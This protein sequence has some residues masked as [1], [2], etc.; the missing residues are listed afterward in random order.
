MLSASS[1][2]RCRLPFDLSNLNDTVMKTR[3]YFGVLMAA[4][5]VASGC[6]EGDACTDT[7]GTKVPLSARNTPSI[8]IDASDFTIGCVQVKPMQICFEVDVAWKVAIEYEEEASDWLVVTPEEG[9]A[10]KNTLSLQAA[11]NPDTVRRE[12]VVTISYGKEMHRVSVVQDA[13]GTQAEQPE[14]KLEMFTPIQYENISG[15]GLH[16][17]K[18]AFSVNSDWKVTFEGRRTEWLS[19]S[20]RE[21]TAG[22]I[23]LTLFIS[24]NPSPDTR[25]AIVLIE[26]GTGQSAAILVCQQGKNLAYVFD[27]EFAR[28]LERRG[29]V[30]NASRIA[31][32]E[33][34]QIETL[35]LHGNW[36]ASQEIYLGQQTSLK[37]I[38]Y[39][40][41][42]ETLTCWGNRLTSLDVSKN[43]A[44]KELMCYSNLIETLDVSG[45]PALHTLYCRENRLTSLDV[46]RNAALAS[47][48][49]GSNL[50]SSID[51]GSNQKL[52]R[53]SC[54]MNPLSS[55]DISRNPCLHTVDCSA[56]GLTSL[57]IS[58]N[59]SMTHVV[60]FNNPGDGE[61][62]P[63]LAWF[64]NESVP[65]DIVE[66]NEHAV[67]MHFPT[68]S[69]TY[70]GRTITPDYRKVK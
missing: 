58:G 11:S 45:C 55:L 15:F 7:P 67:Q 39:F 66:R 64:D 47:L 5:A 3:F 36:D 8:M 35:Q 49:C 38:E 51:V 19:V 60:C 12:A 41:S 22:E 14:P 10:G 61:R 4:M 18:I 26:Y 13:A 44:L 56:A 62:F 53:L 17:E 30:R 6:S 32:D 37:G 57:D 21:G 23:E 16:E 70:E 48:S 28:V 40:E 24:E 46:S 68:K 42:L 20:Q 31:P 25:S 52:L 27:K 63:I 43:K 65:D 1:A 54:K 34:K 29:Y 50:L 33:V 59:R 9:S 69:W 2:F